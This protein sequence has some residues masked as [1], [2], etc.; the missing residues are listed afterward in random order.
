MKKVGQEPPVADRVGSIAAGK[1]A[2]ITIFDGNP[3]DIFTRSMYTIIDG[4]VV[5]DRIEVS[6]QKRHLL[7]E[8]ER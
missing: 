4:Q 2:D 7:P 5:Y 6:K 3:M 8:T 1:D